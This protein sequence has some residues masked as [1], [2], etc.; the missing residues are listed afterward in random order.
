MTKLFCEA[1]VQIGLLTKKG[2]KYVNSSLTNHYLVESSSLYMSKTLDFIKNNAILWAQLSSIIKN[3]PVTKDTKV[4]FA[5]GRLFRIAE[6][7]EA[8]AVFEIIELVKNHVNIQRWRKMLD[9]GGGHG[10]HAIAFA[11]LNPQLEVFVF[12]QPHIIPITSQYIEA[13][14]SEK[15]HVIS[16][17]FYKDR[18]GQCYDA[19]FS[20]INQ[21][22]SDSKFIP[23]F[24]DALNPEG[25]LILR[26]F[27]EKLE[28]DALKTLDWN[29]V[30]YEG[31]KIGRKPYSCARATKPLPRDKYIEHLKSAGFIVH[32]IAPVDSISEIIF[33]KK[34]KTKSE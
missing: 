23:I 25:D 26:R 1:L 16:G 33:A 24:V 3:S 8:G 12:D 9:I 20:S 27:K 5:G 4:E 2:T 15:V 14:K 30:C 13:Y 11:T 34:L 10:L 7:S 17:D 28:I 18:I 19:I 6:K 32:A 21:T 31:R 22:C 29:L